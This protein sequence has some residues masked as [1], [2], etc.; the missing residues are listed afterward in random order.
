MK[1]IILLLIGIMTLTVACQKD[2]EDFA[3][4]QDLTTRNAKT[5]KLQ[6]FKTKGHVIG[7]TNWDYPMIA[8]TPEESNVQ[9]PS[10]V[11]I[12]GHVNLFG[13]FVE[14]ESLAVNDWCTFSITAEGPVIGAG[15]HFE[16]TNP[17]D[18][19]LFG[20]HY[21]E[22][23][24]VTNVITGY[25]ELTGGTGKFEG[26]TGHDVLLNGYRDPETGIASWD[27]EGEM[28]LVLK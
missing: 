26:C 16:V 28:T 9:K 21:D 19:K 17:K 13:P 2:S 12:G 5:E 25:D 14:G 23:N 8:C 10:G 1:N 6:T 11:W 4:A 7:T 18:E 15:S 27:I 20:T 3:S 22:F 24:V